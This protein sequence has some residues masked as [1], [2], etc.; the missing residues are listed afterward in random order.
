MATIDA[1]GLAEDL[2]L[3]GFSRDQAHGMARAIRDR[4]HETLATKEDLARG[5]AEVRAE[6]AEVRAD[7]RA[8]EGRLETKIQQLETKIHEAK[9]SMVMWFAGMMIAQAAAIVALIKLLPG[10]VP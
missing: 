8:M 2:E 4:I 6:I 10:G 7:M 1:L 5:I 9:A 3:A